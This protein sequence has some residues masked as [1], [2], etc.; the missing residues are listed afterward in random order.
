[1]NIEIWQWVELTSYGDLPP[2][3][4]FAAGASVELS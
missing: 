1:M 4:D 3:R 2:P